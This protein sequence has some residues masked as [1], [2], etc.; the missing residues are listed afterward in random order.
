MLYEYAGYLK[1]ILYATEDNARGSVEAIVF[2]PAELAQ[3][4]AKDLCPDKAWSSIP[5]SRIRREDCVRLMGRFEDVRRIDILPADHPGFWAPLTSLGAK[6]DRFPIDLRKFPIFEITYRCASDT[7]FPEVVWGYAAGLQAIA[8]PPSQAWRTVALRIPHFGFPGT[9]DTVTVRLRSTSRTTQSMD[10]ASIRF[11]AMT[12]AEEEALR[13]ADLQLDAHPKPKHFDILDKFLPLGVCMDAASA[14][15]LTE[16]LGLSLPEYWG[17]TLE[18]I[19]KHH[20]NCVAIENVNQLSAGE[21]AE[22]LHCAKTYGMKLVLHLA[23]PQK[24]DADDWQ[25][26]IDRNVKPYAD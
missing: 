23:G 17:L 25:E 6:D 16:L 11:R 7:A 8:L 1:E 19:V 2:G 3:W 12:P 10:I 15:R 26:F 14:R 20:H 21:K 24:G 5:A 13:K 22:L 4:A 18:D 9:L